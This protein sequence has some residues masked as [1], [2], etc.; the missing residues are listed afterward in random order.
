M[1]KYNV[2]FYV[3]RY[4]VSFAIH[5]C[6]IA[7]KYYVLDCFD[8]YDELNWSFFTISSKNW[9]TIPVALR[10]AIHLYHYEG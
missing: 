3:H 2:C 4:S 7:G 9:H 6:I 8:I 10:F 5:V 1:L